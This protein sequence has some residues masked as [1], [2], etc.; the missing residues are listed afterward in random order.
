MGAIAALEPSALQVLPGEQGT[1]TLR[2][3]NAGSVVD[4]FTFDVVGDAAGWISVTP[5]VLRLLP[6][7]EEQATVVLQPPRSADAA[8]G[9]V[10][11]GIRVNS[12]ED[13]TGSVVE[14]GTV[15][16][17]PFAELTAELLPRTSQGSRR[18]R[19]ELAVDN[20]GNDLLNADVI[21]Y[22]DDQVLEF[23]VADPGLVVEPGQ[24]RFTQVDVRPMKRFW[25]GPEKTLP[26]NVVVQS[27]D[28]IP[29]VTLQGTMV[30]R[31]VLPKW[32][33]KAVLALLALLLLLVLLWYFLL[34][35]TIESAAEDAAAEAASEAASEAAA[36]AAGQAVEDALGGPV[37]E[38]Q[39]DI[40]DLTTKV[41]D[42]AEKVGEETIEPR[43]TTVAGPDDIRLAAT[44][45]AGSSANDAF[46]IGEGQTF[47][48]TDIVLQNPAGNVGQLEIRRSG[49]TLLVVAL[50]NFRDLDY[51]F[52]VPVV[53]RE[54]DSLA[55][56]LACRDVTVE[57]STSC[58]A[59]AYISGTLTAPAP[60]ESP[61]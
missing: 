13:P 7:S 46:T 38:Q 12:K 50:E 32:F 29:P 37:A 49:D 58:A 27:Q 31:P 8:A 14:E 2:V 3:R 52:V 18:A 51:H 54:G 28:G 26:F 16:V 39:S 53:F 47:E 61:S 44:A 60:T 34:R 17:A 25:R 15:T 36:A 4:E 33:W 42:V 59:S 41:N 35:P 9:D 1:A 30:Q 40:D 21:A 22:D 11:F 43:E 10:P 20:R 45:P 56:Q 5:E 19:H 23:E 48:L 57:G 55:L 24:A 6:G